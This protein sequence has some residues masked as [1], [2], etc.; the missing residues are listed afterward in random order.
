[1]QISVFYAILP[2]IQD[3]PEKPVIKMYHM[4]ICTSEQINCVTFFY[5]KSQSPAYSKVLKVDVFPIIANKVASIKN[6]ENS[7]VKNPAIDFRTIVVQ[8]YVCQPQEIEVDD[9][10]MILN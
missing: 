4:K 1:M 7:A 10:F 3:L 8:V 5:T 2:L 9:W 6:K